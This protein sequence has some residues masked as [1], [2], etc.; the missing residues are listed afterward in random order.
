FDAMHETLLAQEIE[1]AINRDRC[2]PR[3]AHRQPV[4]QLIGAERGVARQQRLQHAAAD[5][6]QTLGACG[7]DRLGVADGVAG[8]ALMV[9]TGRRENCVAQGF[10]GQAS[11]AFCGQVYRHK[12]ESWKSS[13]YIYIALQQK[14][15]QVPASFGT[16]NNRPFGAISDEDYP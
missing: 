8:A 9:V 1:R 11:S 13:P 7:A 5:R 12:S 3:A 15:E 14:E 10:S 4:D 6:R 16:P 2:R